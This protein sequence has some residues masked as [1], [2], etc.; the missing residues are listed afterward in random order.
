MSSNSA[1]Q[2]PDSP[3]S[4]FELEQAD[5]Y[6]KYMLSTRLEVLFVLRTMI[7]RG[8]MATV[9]FNQ[10]RSFFLTCLLALGSDERSLLMDIGSDEASN[11]EALQATRLIVTTSLDSVKIQ[12]ALPGLRETSC[13]GRP[14]F[15][16]AVPE[17]L[18]RLQ[19]REYFRLEMPLADPVRCQVPIRVGDGSAHALDLILLDIS[20]GGL[21]LM[22]PTGAAAHFEAGTVYPDCR[23]EIP[24]ENVI[25][26]TLGVRNSFTIIPR[27]GQEYL[28]VGCEFI[29]L[30]GTRLTMIQRYITRIERE[31]KARQLERD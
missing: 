26:V 30:P 6:G 9:Y 11:R 1:P 18:L 7:K 31:R 8:C 23:L 19:R 24:G 3:A 15:L 17:T 21:S 12:F 20:G 16:A 2:Q 5:R 25:A 14:A 10:G 13:A 28:R 29:N 4:G 27:T 22:V